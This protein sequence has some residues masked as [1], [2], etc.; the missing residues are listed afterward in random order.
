MTLTAALL[1]L[2]ISNVRLVMLSVALWGLM[3][4]ARLASAHHYPSDIL[5]GTII[6]LV[7]SYPLMHFF[8]DQSI[9]V[10]FATNP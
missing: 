9:K 1:P 6:A 8:G 4:W 7:G 3:A 2:T 5:A 10:F